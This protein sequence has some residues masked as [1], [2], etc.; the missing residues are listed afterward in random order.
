M[1]DESKDVVS[2]GGQEGEARSSEPSIRPPMDIFEDDTG[3]TVQADIPGV[4]RD[5]LNV[6]VEGDT[7]FLEA[8]ADIPVPSDMEALYADVRASRYER[9]FTLSK[10]LDASGIEASL[11][12]G[13]LILRIP[14][15]AEQTP[16]RIEVRV[17]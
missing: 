10:E 15:R 5:G 14:K 1:T 11:H 9:R 16:R 12:D 3:I 13:V 17:G 8:R 4:S 2:G 6:H 7:L